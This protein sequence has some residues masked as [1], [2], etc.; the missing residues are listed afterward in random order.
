MVVTSFLDAHLS[1]SRQAYIYFY[2]WKHLKW[3]VCPSFLLSSRS[4]LEPC[5]VSHHVEFPAQDAGA[6]L[7][8]ETRREN[9]LTW[10]P[11]GLD[12]HPRR[13][14]SQ[15]NHHLP[16]VPTGRDGRQ[17][18]P[19]GRDGVLTVAVVLVCSCY[20]ADISSSGHLS[21]LVMNSVYYLFAM[22]N[23]LRV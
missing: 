6:A 17:C 12:T 22:H 3:Y 5:A 19:A 23:T 4:G 1:L 14:G 9:T 20:S 21:D 10:S 8:S 11:A 7:H 13:W 18:R 2:S 15:V 16:S